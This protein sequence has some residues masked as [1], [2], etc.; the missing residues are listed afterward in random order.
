[1]SAPQLAKEKVG[2]VLV[3]FHHEQAQLPSR[4]RSFLETL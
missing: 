1:M 4:G 2:V 3:V